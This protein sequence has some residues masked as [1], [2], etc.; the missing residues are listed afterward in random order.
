MPV[1]PQKRL[2]LAIVCFFFGYLGIHRLVVGKIGTGLLY[3]CTGGLFAI[4]WLVDL[5]MLL[6]GSFKDKEGRYVLEWL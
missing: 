2:I 6:V 5:I 3:L 4:G 1:S